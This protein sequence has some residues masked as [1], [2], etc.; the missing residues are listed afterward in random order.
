LRTNG[1]IDKY[2]AEAQSSKL[3]N[4]KEVTIQ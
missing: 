2:E 4:L 3:P 1:S